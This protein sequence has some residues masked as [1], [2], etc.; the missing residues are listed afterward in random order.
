M[1]REF[2]VITEALP[3]EQW[4]ALFR[5]LWPHH[6][7]WY[8]SESIRD[9]P[10]YASCRRA[11]RKHMPEML[12]IYDSLCELAGGG[13]LEARFLSLYGPPAYLCACSQAVWQGEAPMLVRNYD[14]DPSSF[15]AVVLRTQWLGRRVIGMSDCVIGLL[16]GMNDAGLAVTLTFGGRRVVGE[17]FGIPIILRYILETCTTV[18]EAAAVLKRVP[19]HMSYNVTILDHAGAWA[20]VFV[21]PDRRSVVSHAAVATNHQERVDWAT[22]AI[23]TQSVE[24]ERVLLNALARGRPTRE[25]FIAAFLQPPVYSLAF[26]QGFGTLYTSSYSPQDRS[27]ELHWPD[28]QWKL[29]LD[30]RQDD[31]QRDTRRVS[32]PLAKILQH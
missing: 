16:D 32:Y 28:G 31:H 10:S 5:S 27:M 20:T 7:R 21:G 3:S 29:H 6:Q 11:L 9:R 13:D 23:A 24:R 22:H 4:A 15:D 1:Q 12:P 26:D 19:C 30:A 17:G 25:Q 2:R 8:L 14:Y 18:A